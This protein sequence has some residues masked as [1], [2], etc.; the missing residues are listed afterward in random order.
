MLL[1]KFLKTPVSTPT[2]ALYLELG[3]FRIGTI[4]KAR[5]INFL[6]YLLNRNESE[7]ISK[8][9]KVQWKSHSKLDSLNY[10]KLEIQK[11]LLL[12]N[13][14]NKQAQTLFRYRT[15]MANFGENYRGQKNS[16]LCPLCNFHLDNQ[17]MGFENC[18]VLRKNVEIS[19][20]YNQIF[21]Q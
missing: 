18:L 5:R 15:R 4:I 2:E 17:K 10:S 8:V 11:Y 9:F 12:E 21:N 1:R 3:I 16:K 6:H 20:N 19:G 14:N 13:L 7:M